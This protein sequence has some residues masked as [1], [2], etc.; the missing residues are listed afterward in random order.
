MNGADHG[1]S[2]H[3]LLAHHK[4]LEEVDDYVVVWRKED[5]D[6]AREKVVDLALASVLRLELLGRYF[7]HLSFL[8][9]DL[10]HM[11]VVLFHVK[12]FFVNYNDLFCN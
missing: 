1:C 5:T 10:V 4:L 8:V 6:V 9:C 11:L 2:Q 7:F 3:L 12:L